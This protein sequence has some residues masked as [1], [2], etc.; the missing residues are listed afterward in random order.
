MS[1]AKADSNVKDFD[2]ISASRRKERGIGPQFKL[3]G[4]VW[5]CLPG[6]P[7]WRMAVFSASESTTFMDALTFLGS[8]VAEKERE[9][10]IEAIKNDDVTVEILNDVIAWLME[11]YSNLPPTSPGS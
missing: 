10:F 7:A 4:K 6:I 9:K 5:P 3:V 11:E 8:L 1:D 2:A